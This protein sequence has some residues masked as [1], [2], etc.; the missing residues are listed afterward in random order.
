MLI[1]GLGLAALLFVGYAAFT[2]YQNTAPGESV[3][4]RVW[5]SVVAAAAAMGAALMSWI[6]GMTAPPT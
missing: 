2:Q 1:L 6:H 3:P 4:K 5:A